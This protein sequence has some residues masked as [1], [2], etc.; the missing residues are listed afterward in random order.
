MVRLAEGSI[1]CEQHQNK[2]EDR[3]AE[4]AKA[5]LP[6]ERPGISSEALAR[7]EQLLHLM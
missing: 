2:V 4:I 1:K 5:K 6:R 7:A 3:E